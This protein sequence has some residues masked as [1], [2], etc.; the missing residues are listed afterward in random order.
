MNLPSPLPA[1]V[2]TCYGMPGRMVRA[3][4]M[5]L[6]ILKQPPHMAV[7]SHALGG[8]CQG[9]PGLKMSSDVCAAARTTH[10]PRKG[11]KNRL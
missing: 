5:S 10:I 7:G 6:V 4:G 2:A 9:W 3:K 11:S 8:R 1:Q